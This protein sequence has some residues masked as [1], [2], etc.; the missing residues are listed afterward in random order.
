[1]Y[2]VYKGHLKACRAIDEQQHRVINTI[3]RNALLKKQRNTRTY[4]QAAPALAIAITVKQA[5]ALH[6][7]E[8]SRLDFSE[9]FAVALADSTT[10]RAHLASKGGGR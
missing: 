6:S 8:P 9:I 5:V 7:F 1:M 4:T 2:N 3:A 10:D